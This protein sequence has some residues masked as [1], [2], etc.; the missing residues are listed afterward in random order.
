MGNDLLLALTI[1]LL[2]VSK[3][4][5]VHAD[6]EGPDLK[7]NSVFRYCPLIFIAERSS[8]IMP[9]CSAIKTSGAPALF[10]SFSL[11]AL[12]FSPAPLSLPHCHSSIMQ[13]LM[14]ALSKRSLEVGERGFNYPR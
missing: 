10:L 14:H 2:L 5:A 4:I 13:G 8:T 1:G 11:C 7:I 12:F 9:S 3:S 6:R